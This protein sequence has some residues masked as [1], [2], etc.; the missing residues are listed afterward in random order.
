[1]GRRKHFVITLIL[2]VIS[3]CVMADGKMFWRE[4]IPPTIPYREHLIKW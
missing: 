3:A 4:T 2:F 1:M